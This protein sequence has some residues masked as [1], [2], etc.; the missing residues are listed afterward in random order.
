MATGT[1]TLPG[2]FMEVGGIGVLLTGESG[3]GKSGLGLALI[4]RGHR[5]VADD[6]AEFARVEE[7]LEGVCPGGLGGFL[8][9]RGL[10]VLNVRAAYGDAAVKERARLGLIIHL[11]RPPE[12]GAVEVDPLHPDYR[13]RRCLGVDVPELRLPLRCDGDP[14]VLVEAAVR[15]HVLRRG[16]YD[17]V[18]DFTARQMQRIQT[19]SSTASE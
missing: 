9:V 14:A 7:G 10:G 18:E 11:E 17:A 13:S 4:G 8:V 3:I 16:G 2:V 6:A 19:V 1:T 15:N 12:D 5:L